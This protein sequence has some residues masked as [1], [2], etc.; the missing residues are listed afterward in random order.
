MRRNDGFLDGSR[1][2]VERIGLAS[3][4]SA[5]CK[6]RS[7]W[8]N[9][10]QSDNSASRFAYGN[11]LMRSKGQ[12]DAPAHRSNPVTIGRTFFLSSSPLSADEEINNVSP[13]HSQEKVS[14]R[15][16]RF[17]SN[18]SGSS[19]HTPV[20]ISRS[21]PAPSLPHVECPRAFRQ[22]Q[23]NVYFRNCIKP[24]ITKSVK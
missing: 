8:D 24:L 1:V 16:F 17:Y 12:V 18:V 20:E 10:R 2:E 14:A 21:F 23:S 6:T 22:H 19:G 11:F 5:I 13:E 9:V 3:K 4:P 7:A 15:G